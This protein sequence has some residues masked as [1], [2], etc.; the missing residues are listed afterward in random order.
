MQPSRGIQKLWSLDFISRC[1][2]T[3]V[4]L[5]V[6]FREVYGSFNQ[7]F[8]ANSLLFCNVLGE[9]CLQVKVV[10]YCQFHMVQPNRISSPFTPWLRKPFFVFLHPDFW[11]NPGFSM[12][13]VANPT[14]VS[15]ELCSLQL[16]HFLH[17]SN[18]HSPECKCGLKK[19]LFPCDHQIASWSA[20]SSP[21]LC[22]P[23]KICVIS[24]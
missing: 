8:K 7:Y 6:R 22:H 21:W 13:G 23:L 18:N 17:S 9:P 20:Q 24:L 4:L 14:P 11:L 12:F 15:N 16:W 2:S 19:R 10:K 3:C 1:L 5:L